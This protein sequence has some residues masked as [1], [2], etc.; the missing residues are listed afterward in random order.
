[1]HCVQG[2]GSTECD[3]CGDGIPSGSDSDDILCPNNTDNNDSDSDADGTAALPPPMW[4]PADDDAELLN[5]SGASA[6]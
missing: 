4:V 2:A 6:R 1:M 5:A 3:E